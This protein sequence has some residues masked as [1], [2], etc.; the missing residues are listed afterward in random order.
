MNLTNKALPIL[1]Q[2]E[3]LDTDYTLVVLQ[4]KFLD[5]LNREDRENIARTAWWAMHEGHQL[6]TRPLKFKPGFAAIFD[7][8]ADRKGAPYRVLSLHAGW[9]E[10]T[11]DMDPEVGYQWHR[12]PRRHGYPCLARRG[13]SLTTLPHRFG[14][15]ATTLA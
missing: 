6:V 2:V 4:S 5:F 14:G 13:R 10:N 15:G 11:D 12:V 1:L 9:N 8:Y 7:Q 3:T